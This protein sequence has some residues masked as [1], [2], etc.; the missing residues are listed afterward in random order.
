MELLQLNLLVDGSDNFVLP[1]LLLPVSWRREQEMGSEPEAV[2]V[3]R[4]V[5]QAKESCFLFLVLSH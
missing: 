2:T 5:A 4:A 1:W 3:E